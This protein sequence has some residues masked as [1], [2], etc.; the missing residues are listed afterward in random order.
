MFNIWS[1]VNSTTDKVVKLD[2]NDNK[3]TL[4][5]FLKKQNVWIKELDSNKPKFKMVLN[6]YKSKITGDDGKIKVLN[7]NEKELIKVFGDIL[8]SYTLKMC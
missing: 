6:Y 2:L 8:V 4:I 5:G 3:I 7:N 1:C